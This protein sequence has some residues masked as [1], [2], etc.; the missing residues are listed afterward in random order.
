M[1]YINLNNGKLI[2]ELSQ[3]LLHGIPMLLYLIYLK[4]L[5]QLSKKIIFILLFD[6]YFF[7]GR[8]STLQV[9]D[10]YFSKIYIFNFLLPLLLMNN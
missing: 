8:F 3:F 4:F 2:L 6:L 7:T 10:I 9:F 5:N 1:L